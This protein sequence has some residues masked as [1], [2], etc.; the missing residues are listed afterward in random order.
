MK[1]VLSLRYQTT[2]FLVEQLLCQSQLE[3]GISLMVGL[4]MQTSL[5]QGLQKY[6]T[7]P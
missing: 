5:H 1:E 6:Q 3:V 4:K 2:P 7:D